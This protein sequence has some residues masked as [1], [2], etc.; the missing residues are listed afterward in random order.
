MNVQPSHSP[1]PHSVCLRSSSKVAS[2]FLSP[3]NTAIG[4]AGE[5]EKEQPPAQALDCPAFAHAGEIFH[6]TKRAPPSNHDRPQAHP[7]R[8]PSTLPR[9]SR[10]PHHRLPGMDHQV[11]L[12][13]PTL[14][15]QQGPHLQ[16]DGQAEER[17][18]V[19]A[20]GGGGRADLLHPPKSRIKGHPLLQ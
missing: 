6:L 3:P 16:S 19:H 20:P 12:L 9:T 2:L 10:R 5:E 13:P 15:Q 14:G 17:F 7:S 18:A 4:D 1:F 11:R 8:R